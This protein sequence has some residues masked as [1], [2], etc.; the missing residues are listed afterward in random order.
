M[1]HK[2]ETPTSV[3]CISCLALS[4]HFS[5]FQRKHGMPRRTCV[6]V[7]LADHDPASIEVEQKSYKARGAW[8]LNR[9]GD[10]ARLFDHG[11]TRGH[12]VHWL[13]A[14]VEHFAADAKVQLG[15]RKN[16]DVATE[17]VITVN[18]NGRQRPRRVQSKHCHQH[19]QH[20]HYYLITT[21][22]RVAIKALEANAP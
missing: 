6:E 20:H 9:Y 14:N 21:V 18:A 22:S 19:H 4:S 5:H 2:L 15:G 10:V 1:Q 16:A 11:V 13:R 7:D 12:V 17:R 3:P 8:R